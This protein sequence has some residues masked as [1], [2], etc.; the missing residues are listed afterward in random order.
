VAKGFA[1]A[2]G[3][4]IYFGPSCPANATASNSTANSTAGPAAGG[5]APTPVL[6]GAT[7]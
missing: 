3:F 5:V 7:A 4:P 2:C 1:S 6:P